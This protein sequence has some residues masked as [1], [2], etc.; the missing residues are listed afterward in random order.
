MRIVNTVSSIFL[1]CGVLGSLGPGPTGKDG[2]ALRGL[3][4]VHGGLPRVGLSLQ[5]F[6]QAARLHEQKT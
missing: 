4:R 3:L 5:T 2:G 6:L 1:K